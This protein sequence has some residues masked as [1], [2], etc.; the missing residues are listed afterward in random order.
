MYF[1]G[2]HA[3]LLLARSFLNIVGTKPGRFHTQGIPCQRSDELPL[4]LF[5]ELKPLILVPGSKL[6]FIRPSITNVPFFNLLLVVHFIAF[7]LTYY[8]FLL[9]F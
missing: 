6:L 7:I 8:S 3:S 1:I 9:T 5:Q 2:Q 4:L